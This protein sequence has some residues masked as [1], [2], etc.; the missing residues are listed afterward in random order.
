MVVR[1]LHY[2]YFPVVIYAAYPEMPIVNLASICRIQ[3][4]IAIE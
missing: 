4:V 1:Q 2:S 3:T